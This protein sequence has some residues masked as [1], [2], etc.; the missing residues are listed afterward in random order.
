MIQLIVH[1]TNLEIRVCQ[2]QYTHPQSFLELTDE[3]EIHDLIGLLILSGVISSNRKNL[4]F[5]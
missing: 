4:K 2:A 3:K 5:L 1:L